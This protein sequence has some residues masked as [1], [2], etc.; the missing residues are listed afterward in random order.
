MVVRMDIV[1]MTVQ[2]KLKHTR[3]HI[4]IH[5]A[6][7]IVVCL[8]AKELF[9]LKYLM[10]DQSSKLYTY[11]TQYKYLSRA[12]CLDMSLFHNKLHLGV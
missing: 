10:D 12:F 2:S 3:K 1:Y 11:D 6:C 5:H 8:A 7:Y 4:R 9:G